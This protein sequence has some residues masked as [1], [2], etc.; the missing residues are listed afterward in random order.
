MD[1]VLMFNGLTDVTVPAGA[2]AFY[3]GLGWVKAEGSKPKPKPTRSRRKTVK[4][5]EE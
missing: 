5:K 2:L 1:K 3:E 4:P